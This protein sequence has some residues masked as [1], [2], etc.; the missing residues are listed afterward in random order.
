VL[1]PSNVYIFLLVSPRWCFN[2]LSFLILW[3]LF[4]VLIVIDGHVFETVYGCWETVE[5]LDLFSRKKIMFNPLQSHICTI[6]KT[7][8]VGSK[9]LLILILLFCEEKLCVI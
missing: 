3:S 2:F 5:L 6:I 7:N 1:F 9:K 4:L 8:Y